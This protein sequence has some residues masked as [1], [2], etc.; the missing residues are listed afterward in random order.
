MASNTIV[1]VPNGNILDIPGSSDIGIPS[2]YARPALPMN[3]GLPW[4]QFM[5]ILRK[6]WKLSLAFLIAV[7]IGLAMIVF[8]LDNVYESHAT[9]EV[10]APAGEN[11][12]LNNGAPPPIVEQQEYLD[13]QT[14][15]LKGDSLA[16]GVINEL[17][18]G[19]NQA[20]QKQSWIQTL[21]NRI[22]SLVLPAR[23]STGKSQTEK[24]LEI[25]K[26]QFNVQQVRA[27][28]L[29]DFTYEFTIP[30]SLRKS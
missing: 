23:S 16:L 7:E 14:Q 15:I 1:R 27:S 8:S 12:S 13:T 3:D 28:R 11:V 6:H 19:E 30:S 18:L 26:G 25:Y 22:I 17:H 5:R 21:P 10:E 24:L 2:G 29:V 9:L 20:F 4:R